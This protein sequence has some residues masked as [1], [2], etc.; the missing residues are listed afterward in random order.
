MRLLRVLFVDPERRRLRSGWRIAIG[1]IGLMTAIGVLA[2]A[3]DA[4]EIPFVESFLWQLLAVPAVVGLAWIL[5]TR[6]DRRGFPAYGLTWQ[7]ARMAMGA[8]VGL[9]LVSLVY[10]IQL[11]MGWTEIGTRWHNRYDV[12]FVAGW[13]IR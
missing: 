2:S 5:A 11:G 7:P 13:P 3:V 1:F 4:I 9:A 6:L 8:L 10:V 12:P